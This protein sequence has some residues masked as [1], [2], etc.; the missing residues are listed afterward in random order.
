M[1]LHLNLV[2]TRCEYMHLL[3]SIAFNSPTWSFRKEKHQLQKL[4]HRIDKNLQNEKLPIRNY[5]L[6][7]TTFL[8]RKIRK[9]DFGE[10][11][12]SERIIFG[13]NFVFWVNWKRWILR[14]NWKLKIQASKSKWLRL[15]EN[16]E[17]CIC[18]LQKSIL[19]IIIIVWLV[20]KREF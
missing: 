8:R 12:K 15:V 14:K 16:V 18:N 4:F 20:S 5:M 6:R 10:A 13:N 17:K 2:N 9:V 3:M 7:S 19:G 1:P 11:K